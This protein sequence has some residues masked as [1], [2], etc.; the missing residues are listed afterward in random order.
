MVKY[1]MSENFGRIFLQMNQVPYPFIR[2]GNKYTF[3]SVGKSRIQK[4]VKFT[5]EYDPDTFSLSFGDV[6]DGGIDDTVVSNNGDI[7]KVLATV[8][9]IAI[10]FL[11]DNSHALVSF[12]GSTPGR[13]AMYER[14]IRMYYES[15][16]DRFS[17]VSLCL[18][19]DEFFL[20]EFNSRG[21]NNADAFLIERKL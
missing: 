15:F 16:P 5:P 17:I 4:I 8:I 10:D 14:I 12:T 6:K 7:I 20:F 18:V 13:T 11:E 3:V 19:N 1:S 2:H 9:A 21:L